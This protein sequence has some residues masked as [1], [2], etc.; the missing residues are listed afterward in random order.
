MQHLH[1]VE[2][3]KDDFE[4]GEGV[5]LGKGGGGDIGPLDAQL[6]ARTRYRAAVRAVGPSLCGILLPVALSG[7]TVKQW[8]AARGMSENKAAGYM[9]AALDRLQD[10]YTPGV[11]KFA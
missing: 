11:R 2:R 7:W 10:H 8:A 6:D 3:L 5:S 4:I 9:I 1:A